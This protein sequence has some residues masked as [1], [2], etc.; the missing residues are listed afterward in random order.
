MS[1]ESTCF[2]S[3]GSNGGFRVSPPPPLFGKKGFFFSMND[4]HQKK[5][6]VEKKRDLRQ[7]K[8]ATYA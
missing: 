5:I 4:L 7:K 6:S 3:S 8:Y 1:V 2:T